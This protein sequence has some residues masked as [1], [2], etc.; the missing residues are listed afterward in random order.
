MPASATVARPAS[1]LSV[2]LGGNPEE[3]RDAVAE[4][5]LDAALA[6]SAASGIR[7]LTI[8]DVAVRAGVGRM[9]VYRRFAGK[10]GLLEALAARE[11]RRCLGE[12]DAASSPDAP[13]AEQLASGFI[14]SLRLAR[15]HP[16]LS[17]LALHEPEALLEALN[18]TDGA[19]FKLARG[20]AAARIG[21]APDG[22]PPGPAAE[23]AA[24]VLIRL[25][26]SFVLI[27]ETSLPLADEAAAREF[28]GRVL[29]PALGAA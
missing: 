1:F 28:A 8:D 3:Q 24:E 23:A 26:F 21:A 6:L 18:A 5:I 29:A 2:A 10:G 16:L 25:M 9:T 19:L 14:T 7:H 4:R 20:F 17:R 22:P 12:L 11:G 27:G 15:E 13:L